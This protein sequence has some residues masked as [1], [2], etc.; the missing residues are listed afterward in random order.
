MGMIYLRV[1]H[2]SQKAA[3]DLILSQMNTG[4]TLASHFFV[5]HLILSSHVFTF[6]EQHILEILLNPSYR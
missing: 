3:T 4:H 6:L 5:I 2:C 1:E